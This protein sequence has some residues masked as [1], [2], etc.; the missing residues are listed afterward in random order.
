M[1]G[2]ERRKMI[3]E[4]LSR[5]N[6]PISGTELARRLGVSRQVVVQD[7]ALL[8]AEDIKIL[9]TN[10]GYILR[11]LTDDRKEACVRVFRSSH[12]TEDILDE[13]QTIVDYGGRILDVFVEHD[14]YGEIHADL[15]INNRLDA[16]EFVDML[17]RSKD[18]PL[19]SL[20]GGCHYHTV[21]ADSVRNLDRIEE[22]LK[23]KGYLAT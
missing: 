16:V 14:V 3:E 5:E 22:E 17:G 21:T 19:K 1:D 23:N 18:L 4:I 8:R 20:T 11:R 2:K 13:L 15:V 12:R 6:R 7:V 10:K 9:S